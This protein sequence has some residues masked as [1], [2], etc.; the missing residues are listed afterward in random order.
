MS[1]PKY[2]VPPHLRHKKAS[3]QHHKNEI[4][5]NYDEK[6]LNNIIT[7]ENNRVHEPQLVLNVEYVDWSTTHHNKSHYNKLS[8]SERGQVND[9][10]LKIYDIYQPLTVDTNCGH[11]TNNSQKG[12][13]HWKFNYNI[14]QYKTLLTHIIKKINKK[15]A[16]DIQIMK[17]HL[18]HFEMKHVEFLKIK[19]QD[20]FIR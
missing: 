9:I 6:Q 13:I 12:Q 5:N 1:G 14:H 7:F 16:N 20:H 19:E 4:G 10:L 2:Y 17:N 8:K 18:N 3:N 15:N 11:K